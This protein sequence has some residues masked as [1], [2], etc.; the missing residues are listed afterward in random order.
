MRKA[1]EMVKSEY[2]GIEPEPPFS[3]AAAEFFCHRDDVS[4]RI[5]AWAEHA[6]SDSP[7]A[8]R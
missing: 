4:E 7:M 1:W 5:R 2:K 8:G 3:P 6:L